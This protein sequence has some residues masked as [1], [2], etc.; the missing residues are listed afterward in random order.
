MYFYYALTSVGYT[1]TWGNAVTIM[2]VTTAL[3]KRVVIVQATYSKITYSN[4]CYE[5]NLCSDYRRLPW[6]GIKG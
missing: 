5:A 1:P 6:R 3:I 2:Q 4:S